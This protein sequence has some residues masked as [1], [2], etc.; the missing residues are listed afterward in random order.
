MKEFGKTAYEEAVYLSF[1]NNSRMQMLFAEYR[2]RWLVAG[3]CAAPRYVI[4][5]GESGAS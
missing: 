5:R 4:P 2:L 3:C 1:D